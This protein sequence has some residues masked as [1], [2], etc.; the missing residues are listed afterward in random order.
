M[1]RKI[2]TTNRDSETTKKTR[3]E[4]DEM[5]GIIKWNGTERE[6]TR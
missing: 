6:E 2:R 4:H 3:T 5:I 1:K